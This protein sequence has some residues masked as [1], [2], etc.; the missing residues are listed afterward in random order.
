MAAEVTVVVT[1]P[2][3]VILVMHVVM[4]TLEIMVVS[5]APEIAIIFVAIIFMAILT[6]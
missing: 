2:G 1:I 6:N 5:V 3:L 4:A